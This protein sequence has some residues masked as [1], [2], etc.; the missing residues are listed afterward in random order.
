MRGLDSERVVLSGGP[1]GI[2]Q[3]CLDLAIP[4]MN[5]RKQFARPIGSFGVMQAKL[6]DMYTALQSSRAYSYGTAQEF[7]LG[8]ANRHDA[9]AC[10]LHASR[11]A[12]HVALETI[13]TLGGNGYINDYAAGRLLRDAKLYEIGAGTTEIRRMLI[14]REFAGTIRW[15]L[16]T[17]TVQL[18][19]RSITAMRLSGILAF[20]FILSAAAQAQTPVSMAGRSAVYAPHGV[21][22]AAQPLAAQAGLNVLVAGGNAI[23]AAVTT[24]AMLN[25]VEPFMSGV[26]GDLFVILW[27]AEEERLVGLNAS[28]RSG[29]LMTMETLRERGHET[30]PKSGA[31]TITV[32]GA[33][34]G[35]AALLERYGTITLAEALGPAI[36]TAEEGFP[37][38]PIIAEEWPVFGEVL[39]ESGR[40][41]Y[42]MGGTRPPRAGEWFRNPEFAR[43]LRAI[44]EQGPEVIYGGPIGQR[45]AEHVQSIGGFL[46]LE[47][48][49]RHT[50]EWVAPIS[51]AFK[52][53]RLWELPPNGQGIAALEM[54]RILE[55]FD[56]AAMDH[57]SARYLHYLIEAKKIAYAD[58][59]QFIGDPDYMEIDPAVLLSDGFIAR[60]RSQLDPS[61][62][63]ERPEPGSAITQ[64]ET[65]YLTAADRHGNMISLISSLGSGF[66]SGVVVPWTGF[67]LQN[68]GVGFSLEEDR[69]N[70]VGPGRRPFHTIIPAFVTRTGRESPWMSYGI[71]GGAQQPQAHVQML[72][73]MV[74]FDM[75][76]QKGLDAARF[77][78]LSGLSV[79]FEAPIGKDVIAELVEMG[80][81]HLDTSTIL[82][83]LQILYGAGQAI[84]RSEAGGYVAG[85]DPRRDGFAAG[86]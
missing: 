24:A 32:P 48:L 18:K 61:R 65:T 72:L 3:A 49:K 34:S 9:A 59:R 70:T 62:A 84:V 64:S 14:G 31:E 13:Q 41:A 36:R 6:A 85:S 75:D 17:V 68:R 50:V 29:A 76:P 38:S 77:N 71:V 74:V 63:A 40:E 37:V 20:S 10:L 2:M 55:P 16:N 56:L 27:S 82:Q 79:G 11:A 8:R 54:L 43:T 30:M 22:A 21:V 67:A 28:G 73:N 66:G 78:H 47:D 44:A 39:D 60:R 15:V 45:I 83:G 53:Y 86:H 52:G 81:E 1:I 46:T 23:D 12:V 58:L 19:T 69:P 26:G 57:N 25:L 4:Y 5:E 80:H 33:L 42:Y 7:E 51:V 35:W